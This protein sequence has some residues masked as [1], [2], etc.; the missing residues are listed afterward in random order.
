MI[1][2]G[3][4][5]TIEHYEQAIARYKSSGKELLQSFVG[6]MERT[7]KELKKLKEKK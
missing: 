6:P 3:L 1:C 4:D 2:R 5:H 7:L